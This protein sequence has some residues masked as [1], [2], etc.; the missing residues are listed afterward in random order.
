MPL[1]WT[2]LGL[3]IYPRSATAECRWVEPR[4]RHSC[5]RRHDRGGRYSTQIARLSVCAC[6]DSNNRPARVQCLRSSV[7]HLPKKVA[8]N[9]SRHHEGKEEKIDRASGL[10]DGSATR[11][12]QMD[13][14]SRSDHFEVRYRF[15]PQRLGPTTTAPEE[16]AIRPAPRPE[17]PPPASLVP[18]HDAGV[19]GDVSPAPNCVLL[20]CCPAGRIVGGKAVSMGVGG[21]CP[22]P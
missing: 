11:G 10:Q 19:L 1:P 22:C 4:R 17:P 8:S 6:G 7:H 16:A 14:L 5:E 3:Y 9:T 20:P 2:G 15:P 18:V 12:K 13:V 21:P